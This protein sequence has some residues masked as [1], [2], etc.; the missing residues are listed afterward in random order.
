MVARLEQEEILT[1]CLQAALGRVSG[2]CGCSP[3]TSCYGCLRNYRNQ[4]AHPRLARGPVADYLQ[5]VLR[6]WK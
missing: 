3:D 1:A 5:R 4:F 2:G 6:E